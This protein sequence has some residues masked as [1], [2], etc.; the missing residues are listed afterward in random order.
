L[1]LP[2]GVDGGVKLDSIGRARDAGGEVLVVGSGL[3]SS[4]GDLT[5]TVAALRAAALAR[6]ADIDAER[7]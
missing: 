3:Y 1:D 6:D 4:D 2:I 5:P 7:T